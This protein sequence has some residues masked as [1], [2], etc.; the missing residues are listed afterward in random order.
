M[1]LEVSINQARADGWTLLN[2]AGNELRKV[3]PEE[4]TDLK[5]MYGY[6]TLKAAIRASEM[7]DLL[8]EETSQGSRLVYRPKVEILSEYLSK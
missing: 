3:I 7:F 1:L 2:H 5:R 4:M 8:E 6:K